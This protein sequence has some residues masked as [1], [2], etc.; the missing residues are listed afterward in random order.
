VGGS[1]QT[2]RE[3]G[4][5]PASAAGSLRATTGLGCRSYR[6]LLDGCA[7]ELLDDLKPTVEPGERNEARS[8]LARG[9]DHESAAD[10]PRA[11]VGHQGH[12]RGGAPDEL[13]L[14][15]IENDQVSVGLGCPQRPVGLKRRGDVELAGEHEVDDAEPEV[16]G[17]AAK[18]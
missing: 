15:Q 8:G 6:H 17:D 1:A 14:A 4:A 3:A 9:D 2:S 16:V 18:A 13:H 12:T 10:A 7:W 11:R 5:R